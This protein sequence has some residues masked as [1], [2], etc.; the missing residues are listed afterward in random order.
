VRASLHR[1][2]VVPGT[3]A[4]LLAFALPQVRAGQ[5]KPKAPAPAAK[6]APK[7]P[8]NPAKPGGNKAGG[9]K[10]VPTEQLEKLL[11]MS[12]EERQKAL[13]K[14]PPQQ[15][16]QLQTRLDNLDRMTPAQ[17]QQNLERTRQLEALTPARRQAV[18]RQIQSMNGLSVADQRE[19]L[20]NPD[21]G[22][23]FSPQEQQIIRDRFAPA[24]SNVVKPTD[25]LAP[26]RRQAVNQ[27]MQRINQ[28]SFAERQQALHS[29][30]FN[31]NFSPEEQEILR[32]RFPNA[33]K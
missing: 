12:Q 27:E 18:T 26:A 30:E 1:G 7:P 21:F 9:P 8:P 31:Q 3:L 25:K 24:T 13:S 23:S 28:M 19:I 15:Q 11:N 16:K 14:L 4:L 2:S 29:P 22:K 17:R 6:P 32:D 5:A 10:Q 33:A 20:N